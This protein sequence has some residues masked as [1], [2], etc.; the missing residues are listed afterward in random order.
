MIIWLFVGLFALFFTGLPIALSL[1]LAS[2]VFL[3]LNGSVPL[4][5]VTQ[6]M[7]TGTDSFV[8]LAVP[9]FLLSGAL[10]DYGGIS[11][12]LV[13]FANVLVGWMAGGL[14]M[15]S[16]VASMIFAG[17][18]GSAAADC[19]AIG[20]IMIPAMIRKGYAKD[21]TTAL[22]SSAGT[23]GVIIPPSVPMVVYGVIAST[24]IGALFVA[25]AIPG[26]LMGLA[27]MGVSFA[28]CKRRGYVGEPRVSLGQAVAAF[29]DAIW[30]LMMP[31]IIVGG[32]LGGV[33]TPTEA[34]GVATVYAL[35]VGFFVYRELKLRDMP[36]LLRNAGVNTALVMFIISTASLFAW[37]LASQQV[38]KTIAQAFLSFS[39]DPAVFLLM[40]NLLLL[41][42]GTFLETTAA[43]IIFAPV[44]LPVTSQLHI[45]PIFLGVVMV[46]NLAI[47]MVTPPMGVSLFV[48]CSISGLKVEQVVRPLIPFVGAMIAVLFLITY[49]PGLIMFLPGLFYGTR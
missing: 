14:S 10:M 9:L 3:W 35:F 1:A 12:R 45:D 13:S 8:L 23:I 21:F 48:G 5:V 40:L 44:L 36:R 37:I 16:V 22:Q 43:L 29:R 24:S 49:V 28:V 32:I 2:T 26:I 47:G 42:V 31:I 6:R 27:L 25:G 39:N 19:A 17:I 46:V 4:T 41:W 34:A 20:S 30:A 38:P 33:F 15:I 18:S 11:K 7:I